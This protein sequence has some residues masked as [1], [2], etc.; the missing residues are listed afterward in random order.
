M[1]QKVSRTFTISLTNALTSVIEYAWVVL[2][3]LVVIFGIFGM[4]VTIARSPAEVVVFVLALV[5]T[6][7]V[8]SLSFSLENMGVGVY[9]GGD[10]VVDDEGSSYGGGSYGRFIEE[11]V[12]AEAFSL[13]NIRI[14]MYG[15]GGGVVNDDDGDDEG[16]GMY[17]GGGGVVNDDDGDDEGSG[18]GSYRCGG[19]IEVVLARAEAGEEEVIVEVVLTG[20]AGSGEVRLSLL[21]GCRDHHLV[22]VVFC[23]LDVLLLD[24]CRSRSRRLNCFF[25][26]LLPI[27]RSVYLSCCVAVLDNARVVL[28]NARVYHL[29]RSWWDTIVVASFISLLPLCQHLCHHLMSSF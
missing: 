2:K 28:D 29:T 4:G 27:F 12:L 14:G 3:V 20:A 26:F 16:S 11:V 7:A 21:F 17:G 15:G 18:S 19:F 1:C 24:V 9:G 13:E 8:L 5:V 25:S 6:A 22:L 23:L 10:V